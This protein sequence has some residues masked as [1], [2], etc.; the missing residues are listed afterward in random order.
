MQE[1]YRGCLVIGG[2]ET[3]GA[4]TGD[5]AITLFEPGRP[6]LYRVTMA[7]IERDGR[8]LYMPRG[9]R[10]FQHWRVSYGGVLFGSLIVEA[11]ILLHD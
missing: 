6:R 11:L 7:Q 9:R 2:G 3:A 10:E 4:G 8:T 5:G 1:K